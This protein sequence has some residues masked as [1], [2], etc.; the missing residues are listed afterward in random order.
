MRDRNLRVLFLLALSAVLASLLCGCQAPPEVVIP[1]AAGVTTG[2]AAIIDSFVN[3]GIMSPEQAASVNAIAKGVGDGVGALSLA[4]KSVVD[5]IAA[6]KAQAAA[7]AAAAAEAKASGVSLEALAATGATATA[8][9]AVVT[10]LV[11]GPSAPLAERAKR[12]EAKS[13]RTA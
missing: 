2:I 11:R 7:A 1:A 9:G 13:H 10:N 8:A 6:A 3:S 5:A 12:L 4:V